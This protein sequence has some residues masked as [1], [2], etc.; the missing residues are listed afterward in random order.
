MDRLLS[1]EIFVKSVELGHPLPFAEAMNMSFAQWLVSTSRFWAKL[2]WNWL[3]EQLVSQ[4]LTDIGISFYERSKY[5][6]LKWRLLARLVQEVRAVQLANWGWVLPFLLVWM[7]LRYCWPE[8]MTMYPDIKSGNVFNNERSIFNWWRF[9]MVAF[10]LE[11]L[12]CSWFNCGVH[13]DLIS[14][15][16]CAGGPQLYFLN[17]RRFLSPTDLLEHE[18]LGFSHTELR[19]HWTFLTESGDVGAC[20][21]ALNVR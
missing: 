17:I 16:Y 13:W 15:F 14:W 9:L 3:I 18:C 11:T 5:F 20:L 8:Y 6:G 19:T 7:R 12:F 21:R 4:H 1:I 10:V 2:V